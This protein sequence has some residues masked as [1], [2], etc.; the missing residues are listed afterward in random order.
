MLIATPDVNVATIK[1]TRVDLDWLI[2]DLNHAIVNRDCDDENAY[3]LCERF[4]FIFETGNCSRRACYC[5]RPPVADSTY[6]ADATLT[7]IQ[8]RCE[9]YRYRV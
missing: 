2:S 9:S 5:R 8:Q 4:E 1:L 3:V 7:G 6:V